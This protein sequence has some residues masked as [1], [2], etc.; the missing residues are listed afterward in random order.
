[1]CLIVQDYDVFCVFFF[2]Y[3]GY[4]SSFYRNQKD[5]ARPP[6][7]KP[8]DMVSKAAV[9]EAVEAF[10]SRSQADLDQALPLHVEESLTYLQDYLLDICHS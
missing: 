9:R 7:Y 3:T 10:L 5:K 8:H 1:M 2:F 4:L 6:V